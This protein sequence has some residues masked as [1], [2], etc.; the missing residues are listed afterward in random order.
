MSDPELIKPF[1]ISIDRV[2]I[3]GIG[4]LVIR[5][6]TPITD[7]INILMKTSRPLQNFKDLI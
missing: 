2:Y 7:I 6:K 4:R 1:F 5:I 3:F